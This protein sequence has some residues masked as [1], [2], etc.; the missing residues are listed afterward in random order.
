MIDILP[1]IS[2]LRN[3]NAAFYDAE[4]RKPIS[5]HDWPCAGP[6]ALCFSGHTD[7]VPVD[8]QPWT[9][10][11]CPHAT[12]WPLLRPRSADMK[13]F[14]AC[15]LAAIPDFLAQPPRPPHRGFSD[16]EVM[17][18]VRSPV[19][20]LQA[21]GRNRRCTATEMRPSMHQGEAGDALRCS[22]PRLPPAYAP[23]GVKI[24]GRQNPVGRLD[25]LGEQLAL[26]QIRVLIRLQHP[27]SGGD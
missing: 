14:L 19:A 24:A 22:R 16:E 4:G 6:A 21:S 27:A 11:L 2:R 3:R 15:V 7:V 25:E 26:R 1:I 20:H 17:S 18:G 12:R 5:M 13:G 9:V 23:D 8:G 10:P